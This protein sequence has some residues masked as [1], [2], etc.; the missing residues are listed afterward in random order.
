MDVGICVPHYGKPIE[1]ERILDIARQAET[2]GFDSVWVTDHII[3]PESM[4]IIYRDNMLEPVALLSHLAAV[5][6]RVRLGTSVIILPYRSPVVLAK[7][8]ATI[9]QLS[10][11]RVIL[12]TGAGWME[13]EFEALNAPFKDR[14]D[15]CDEALQVIRDIW[16]H[17]TVSMQGQFHH[18]ENMQTSP[19][20]VQAGGPPIW[21]G[22]NSA[23]SRRRAAELGDGWH[24]SSLLAAQ[25]APG[26]E[27]IRHL[28]SKNNRQGEPVFSCRIAL[29]LDGVSQQVTSYASRQPRSSI[30]GSI[31]A[32]V[33]QFGAYQELGLSHVV[34]EMSTQSHAGTLATMETFAER[35][36]PQL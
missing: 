30:T 5:V 21:V 33:E 6:T 3:V 10:Q 22:G 20:P 23:R 13:E 16:R 1:I 24:A 7:M 14:G 32:A 2:L 35:I 18:Y 8:L 17:E 12:G 26:C 25:M 31:E 27:H 36:R 34:L 4:N 15:F 11:G 19:R 29:S 9:D 28:W